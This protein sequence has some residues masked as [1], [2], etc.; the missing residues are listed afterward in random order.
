[1]GLVVI[2]FCGVAQINSGK[3]KRSYS[4]QSVRGYLTEVRN[5]WKTRP[6]SYNTIWNF[7]SELVGGTKS[8]RKSFKLSFVVNVLNGRIA[9]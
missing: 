9:G 3:V 8:V 1:M 5:K 2:M 7:F 4:D 6:S